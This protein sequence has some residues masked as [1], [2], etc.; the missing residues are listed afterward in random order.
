[1]CQIYG[2]HVTC[3]VLYHLIFT[4]SLWGKINCYPH[5][6]NK[7][8]ET[9]WISDRARIQKHEDES[10]ARILWSHQA[11]ASLSIR[12]DDTIYL[13]NEQCY[14]LLVVEQ[15]IKLLLD[16]VGLKCLCASWEERSMCMEWKKR[17]L[18]NKFGGIEAVGMPELFWR[19]ELVRESKA[20]GNKS[21]V[22]PTFHGKLRRKRRILQGQKK[23]ERKNLI[24]RGCFRKK[25][26]SV[27]LNTPTRWK[28][29]V[30]H[31]LEEHG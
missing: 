28:L 6:R 16:M 19:E 17:D 18:G 25:G 30:V 2:E 15:R 7:N 24:N 22:L 23:K 1:M 12:R 5:F 9:Q 13:E 3:S 10:K 8:H 21:W 27:A 29:E 31:W 26:G 20:I 4:R 11:E 14:W